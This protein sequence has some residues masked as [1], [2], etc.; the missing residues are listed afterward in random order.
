MEQKEHLTSEGL[1]KI[2]AIKASMNSGLSSKLKA[3]T[4]VLPV[5]RPLIEDQEIQDPN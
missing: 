1:A 2:V 3:F 5:P 4:H